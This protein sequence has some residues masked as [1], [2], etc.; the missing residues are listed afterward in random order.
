[1]EI[2]MGNVHLKAPQWEEMTFVRFLWGD[3]ETME[4]VGGP[5]YMNEDQAEEWFD[6]MVDPG[7]PENYYRLII[8]DQDEP[9]G[10]ISFHHF[11]QE[12][13][14]AMFNIKVLRSEQGKGYARSAMT[15]FLNHFF[16]EVGGECMLDDVGLENR[17]GQEVLMRFGF[18]RNPGFADVCR[19]QITR[20]EFNRRYAQGASGEQDKE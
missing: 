16:N 17:I 8:N 7:N 19:L 1:M 13:G 10:E 4:P 12:N 3:P 11:D 6:K 9:V 20:D 2:C 18:F 5:Q 15:Q 14:T